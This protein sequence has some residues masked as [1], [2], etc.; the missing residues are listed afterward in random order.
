MNVFWI[1]QISI[2]QQGTKKSHQVAMM[3]KIYENATGVI[4]YA[5]PD[6]TETQETQAGKALTNKLINQFSDNIEILSNIS[7]LN[8]AR[9]EKATLPVQ[10]FP[11]SLPSRKPITDSYV[12]HGWRWLLQIVYGAWTERVWIVQELLLSNEL[13]ILR[14]RHM[15]LWDSIAHISFLY[16]LD[17]SS[18]LRQQVNRF[19]RE[20]VFD[21][22]P[23]GVANYLFSIW[24]PRQQ[25]KNEKAITHR[26]LLA[27]MSWYNNLECWDPRD[28][29][30]A[31]LSISRDTIGL[32][33]TPDYSSSSPTDHVYLDVSGWKPPQTSDFWCIPANGRCS[34]REWQIRCKS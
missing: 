28:R 4:V 1:D 21:R 15:F 32:G 27:N 9:R 33:I 25:K 34:T 5:G 3:G 20:I 16:Y 7:S 14:G 26:K 30:Y 29:I 12:L 31:M 2:D 11:T 8:K 23:F 10:D 6:N 22:R 18:T 17:L 19:W 24:Q 13:Y